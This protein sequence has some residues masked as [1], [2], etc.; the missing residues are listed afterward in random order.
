MSEP[1]WLEVDEVIDMHAEQLAVFG[2]PEGIRDHGL[3]ES[4]VLRPV[5]QWHYGQTDMAALAA[6]YAFGLARNHA[7]VD[8]NK[9][10]AFQ[11]MMVFLRGNDI[12]FAPDP[13]HATE[14]ILSLAA[15]E[16]SEESLTRW[17]RDNWPAEP[18]K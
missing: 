1:I 16:V 11:A 6:A 12:A 7:F 17:I 5:N 15:G 8:G 3:L 10:I 14:I 2:G 4:A 18:G 9:R 13:A